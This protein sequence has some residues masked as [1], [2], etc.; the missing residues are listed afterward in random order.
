MARIVEE[1][2][3]KRVSCTACQAVIEYLPEDVK[4]KTWTSM[5]EASGEDH[6]KCPRLSCPGFGI[7]RSW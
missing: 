1:P 5:G 7:I 4:T 3:H 2:K 6:V